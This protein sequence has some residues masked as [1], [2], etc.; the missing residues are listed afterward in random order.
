MLGDS[1]VKESTGGALPRRVYE[2]PADTE[3]V[4]SIGLL[5]GRT[6]TGSTRLLMY[7]RLPG[8][9]AVLLVA[10]GATGGATTTGALVPPWVT[11]SLPTAVGG[12]TGSV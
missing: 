3:S 7:G 11:G 10:L 8:K 2:F 12:N 5:G 9:I 1:P 4:L 6:V